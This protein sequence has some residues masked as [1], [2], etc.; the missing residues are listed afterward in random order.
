MRTWH[1]NR[2]EAGKEQ[3]PRQVI[4]MAAFAVVELRALRVGLNAEIRQA[5]GVFDTAK[6]NNV[7]HADVVMLVAGKPAERSLRRSV[8][9]AAKRDIR[10]RPASCSAD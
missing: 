6:A 3:T 5:M 2:A 8:Y 7:A 1:S 10:F 4:A 9:E